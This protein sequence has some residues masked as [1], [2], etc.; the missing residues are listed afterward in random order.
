MLGVC[1][2]E[3]RCFG[4]WYR[5]MIWNVALFRISCLRPMQVAPF[6]EKT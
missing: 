4:G 2:R 5:G 3:V 1:Q 6:S